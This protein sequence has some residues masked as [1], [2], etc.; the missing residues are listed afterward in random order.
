MSADPM[1]LA[2]SMSGGGARAAYQVGVMLALARQVSELRI[3]IVTGVSAGAINAAWFAGTSGTLGE[4][5]ERLADLWRSLTTADVFRVDPLTLG[6]NVMRWGARLVSGGAPGAPPVRGLVD[7]APLRAL[8]RRVLGAE[9]GRITGVRDNVALG[10]LRALAITASS[11]TTG[12]SVTWVTDDSV[13]D[14]ERPGRR[15]ALSVPDVEHVMASSALPFVFPAISVG[16]AWYGDGGMRLL[17]PLAPAIHLGADRILAVSTRWNAPNDAPAASPPYPPPAQ[18]AG[19]MLDAVFLDTL[20]ADAARLEQTNALIER[21]PPG[22]TGALRRIALM[23]VRPS[24]N[25]GRLVAEH[26]ARLPLALRFLMRGLGTHEDRHHGLMSLLMFQPDYLRRLIALGESDTAAR[27]EIA[28]FV[29]GEA[30]P[31]REW[32]A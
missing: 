21:L 22:A 12:E 19:A 32:S 11:Y 29:R 6:T 15:S 28:A 24:C 13:A 10:R 18:V 4:Q 31:R 5:S 14:W 8:L 1:T 27:P 9:D 26:E 20:D 30:V 23:V 2:V 25:I 3:P 16:D 7:T 17:A